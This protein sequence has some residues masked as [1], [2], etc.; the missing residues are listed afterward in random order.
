MRCATHRVDGEE[1]DGTHSHQK[2]NHIAAS[3]VEHLVDAF[4]LR[5]WL[6]T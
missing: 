6:S 5:A 3:D 4:G 2:R 1:S